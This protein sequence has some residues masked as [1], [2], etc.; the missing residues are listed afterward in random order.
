MVVQGLKKRLNMIAKRLNKNLPISPCVFTYGFKST[1]LAIRHPA[2]KCI[3]LFIASIQE[4]VNRFTEKIVYHHRNGFKNHPICLFIY[5]LALKQLALSYN[6]HLLENVSDFS[7]VMEN[8][9]F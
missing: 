5:I 1:L 8:S 4:A 6:Y 7:R 2:E 3:T 9:C